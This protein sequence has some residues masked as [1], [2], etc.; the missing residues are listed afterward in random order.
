MNIG[1]SNVRTMY[2]PG[3]LQNALLEMKQLNI[4]LMGICEHKWPKTGNCQQDD[5]TFYY[6]GYD[7]RNSQET[8]PRNGVDIIVSRRLTHCIIGFTSVSDCLML[9]QMQGVQYIINIV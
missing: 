2:Q 5:G 4:D 6:S 9:L 8:R 1:T 7:S 3:R